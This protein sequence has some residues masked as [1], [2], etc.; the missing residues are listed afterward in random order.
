MGRSLRAKVTLGLAIPLILILTTFTII[1]FSNYRADLFDHLS[2]LASYN[3]QLI[4]DTLQHSM[5]ESNF[6]DVQR[7][8]DVVG[9]NKNYRVVY[10][11]N[12]SGTIIFAPNQSGI[13]TR[14]D[15][16]NPTCRPCHDLSV[17][18]R[19]S[20]IMVSAENGQ[21]VFRS[22]QPIE[23]SPECSNCH[24]PNQRLIGL[25]L[26]DI[27]TAPFEA[28]F[29]SDVRQNVLWALSLIIIVILV[30]N[31]VLGRMV[32]TPL[33]KVTAALSKF[34][35][36]DRN[37]HLLEDRKDEIGQLE[38]DFNAM[39]EQ[40]CTEE[41]E[42]QALS[43]SFRVQTVR[44]Q[45]LLKGLITAQEDERKRVAREI[46]DEL[47]Q[48]LSGL[49][50][51]TEIA[52]QSMANNPERTLEQLSQTREL[53]SKTTQQMYE[54]ILAL[55]PSI[56]DD[57]GLAAALR[58]LAKRVLPAEKFVFTLDSTRLSGRLQ[59]AIE[60]ALYRI[61][62]EA[63]SNIVRHSDADRVNIT[64]SQAD[65]FF[66]GEISDNGKGLDMSSLKPEKD[67]PHGLGILGM[68][69]RAAQCGGT[70]EFTSP[71]GKGTRI[72]IHIP[73]GQ[74]SHE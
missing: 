56:L 2:R 10:L 7:V 17:T 42:K 19:P 15:N 16:T 29:A 18:D 49:A 25:L 38:T 52:Q 45:E 41:A 3:G 67:N 6:D 74:G 69:E 12:T 58:S 51:Q 59:P 72:H 64:L 21:R 65:G 62:Q 23:N 20:G 4:K 26:T 34:G 55:R 11:L 70:I 28:S 36:G 30:V 73:T 39:V 31:L 24:D 61:F 47:G 13:G 48:S 60:T 63:M 9:N 43:E 53:I 68:Q 50:L 1:E 54:L 33:Q 32:I 44:Q 66:D 8:L 57:L 46:H 5:L 27:Y 40:I 71:A 37:L 22:M 14:L 35:S